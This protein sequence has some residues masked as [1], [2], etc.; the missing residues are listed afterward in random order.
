MKK[1]QKIILASGVVILIASILLSRWLGSQADKKQ[2]PKTTSS[3]KQARPVATQVVDVRDVQA[4]IDITGRLQAEDKIDIYAEVTGVLLPTP[5]DFKVGNQFPRGALMLRIDNSEARQSLRSAKSNFINTLA[6]VIPDLEIDYPQASE[7]W[8]QYL[9]ALNEDEALP[10]LPSPESQKI[11][12]FLTARQVYTQYYDIL[13]AEERLRKYRLYAPFQGT[14]TQASINQGTLVRSGQ[15]L[16]EFI[17]SG[18]YELETAISSS[19]LPYVKV[20]DT[21]TLS[22]LGQKSNYEGQ[23]IRINDQ[24]E[25]RTQTVRLFVRIANSDLK[26]GMYM[27]GRIKG[28]LFKQASELRRDM[29][30]NASQVFVL[31]DSTAV[32]RPVQSLKTSDTTAIV[33]GL[34][35]G[36]TVITENN[37]S[38]FEGTRVVREASQNE[39]N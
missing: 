37:L 22:A 9:M 33:R 3:E 19:E 31:E 2:S 6:S 5:I 21:V 27:Q 7:Q 18:V 39:L 29:L 32:L 20:G 38:S 4:Y 14:L 10:S 25:S 36:T 30:V 16:G 35:E 24:V 26:A 12:L 1:R 11:K 8:N 28:R 23:I 34:S 17:R 15:K 13:Q